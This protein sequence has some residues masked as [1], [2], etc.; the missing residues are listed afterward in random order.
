M[1]RTRMTGVDN[2]LSPIIEKNEIE[3]EQVIAG[4]TKVRPQLGN[5]GSKEEEWSE[6]EAP[7]G[8]Y[9]IFS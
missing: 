3:L 8:G 6:V 2:Y 4:S 1:E 5:N 7:G 9:D